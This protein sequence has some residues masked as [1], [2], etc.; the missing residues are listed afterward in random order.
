MSRVDEN[1]PLGTPTWMEL[2][3]ADR[4]AAQAYYGALPRSDTGMD[5][6]GTSIWLRM[7]ATG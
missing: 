7:I 5:R 2:P 3:V 4:P 1:Q 6:G